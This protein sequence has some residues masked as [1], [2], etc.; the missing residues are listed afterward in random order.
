M[1]YLL[2]LFPYVLTLMVRADTTS[3]AA[4]ISTIMTTEP[5]ISVSETES[6]AESITQEAITTETTQVNMTPTDF[7]SSVTSVSDTMEPF[8]TSTIK[9]DAPTAR[10]STSISSINGENTTTGTEMASTTSY[11]LTTT[12]LL[13]S[14]T[15]STTQGQTVSSTSTEGTSTGTTLSSFQD[16]IKDLN[17]QIS[18]GQPLTSCYKKLSRKRS[19]RRKKSRSP[20]EEFEIDVGSPFMTREPVRHDD[21]FRPRC[22]TVGNNDS[23][24]N[25]R[26]ETFSREE[27]NKQRLSML[28]MIKEGLSSPDRYSVLI[29][30]QGSE[31]H[32][33]ELN[34]NSTEKPKDPHNNDGEIINRDKDTKDASSGDLKADQETGSR[35]SGI[36]EASG[37]IPTVKDSLGVSGSLPPFPPKRASANYAPKHSEEMSS[38]LPPL[39]TKGAHDTLKDSKEIT[40]NLSPQ[41]TKVGEDNPNDSKEIP[42]NLPPQPTSVD[43]ENPKEESNEV[44]NSLPPPPPELKD[45][46]NLTVETSD[47]QDK[48]LSDAL[49]VDTV[50]ANAVK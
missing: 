4:D 38:N 28:Q 31:I 10:T 19:T 5:I 41:P 17:G 11:A 22:A 47:S 14:S 37:V 25:M 9:T 6:T 36:K 33:E 40:E 7:S 48:L 30:T 24:D 15:T 35:K 44:I 39:P 18:G 45:P 12:V 23:G 27:E 43:A 42:D 29:E 50:D 21:L 20:F 8:S 3:R 13:S 34:R 2:L 26:L 32:N 16:K 1:S 49:T 46:G